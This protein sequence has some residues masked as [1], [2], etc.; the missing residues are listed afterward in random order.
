ML[1][2][3]KR[4][5][6]VLLLLVLLGTATI[7]GL[8][9]LS[10]PALDGKG[11][12]TTIDSTVTIARDAIGQAVVSADSRADASYGLG[13]AHG[14]D[15]FF[16]MDLLRRN[17]AGEL[18]EL[19]GSAAIN[20]DESMRFHQFRKRAKLIVMSLPESYQLML[21]RYTQGVND[22]R[23]QS[24]FTSFEYLLLGAT[25]KPW[26]PEDSLLVIFSMYLD[27]QTANFERD[28]ALIA[29]KQQYGQGMLDFILQ[30]SH[31]QAA[32]DG[33]VITAP[34]AAIPVIE[35]QLA[36][37]QP[38]HIEDI[39]LYGSNNW[40]V[41]GALTKTGAAMLSDDMHLGLTVPSIWYR[42][43]L[44][45]Q[46][47]G[48]E[49]QVTGVSLP[50]APA[51]VVGSNHHI[52]WGFTNGYLDAADWVELN[53]DTKTQQI[54]EEIML[55]SG[56][57]HT[58]QLEMSAFG[59]VKQV[60]DKKF[61]LSWVAHQPYAVNLELLQFELF[62]EV[63]EATA[64]AKNV[65]IPVQNLVVVD[66]QGS[67]AWTPIGAIPAR[68][69]ARDTALK[70]EEYESAWQNNERIRPV[71]QNP[72]SGKLWTANARVVS[73][74]DNQ[75]FGDGG[76]APGARAVQIRDGLISKQVFSEADF[77]QLQLD[78]QAK[79][80]TPWHERLVKLLQTQD[81]TSFEKDLRLLKDWQGCAC[82]DS[83]G[84]TLVKAYRNAL[85]DTLYAPL[86]QYLQTQSLSL[87]SVKGY[88][89]PGL[90]QLLTEQ[91]NSWLGAHSSWN[92]LELAA[93]Q[94][95]KQKLS[96]RYGSNMAAW[97]W[98][99][100]NALKV[101]HPFSKQMPMLSGLL[102][103]PTT[104]AFGD[105]FMPAVQGKAFGAS[106]RFIAQPGHLENAILTVAGG[107]SG[108]PL[109]PFYRTGFNDYAEGGDTPLLPSKITH[110]I[111][112]TP[113]SSK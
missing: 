108:H 95:A 15:R 98:G 32:L 22:G 102:D 54:A 79:F 23:A 80:L 34:T 31:H 47:R 21:E 99:D 64:H 97:R 67:A 37:H 50:G 88:F 55:P 92:E 29:L 106:Q 3:I 84:Y 73:T 16:Q 111:V 41:T 81:S 76:Y 24:G 30:P 110:Q 100:V 77:Y 38:S 48:K 93:Y 83:V 12:A 9:A 109:S 51:I 6:V 87:K 71:V 103:M 44:N 86:E 82:A 70:Q 65:G 53:S 78:N 25:P 94:L 18:S 62:S 2:W 69:F 46:E 72:E 85:I 68:K 19:F 13:F 56:E 74:E 35:P 105:T 113:N 60:G 33:S 104:Q 17:A 27:L 43:Q 4:I 26:L 8:L 101:Q 5:V 42:A 36:Q 58:Y 57:V 75:R 112:I 28:E 63:G 14:Q 1:T 39:P 90:W 66:S 40:A 107:Q 61:A 7:Y 59:P 96:E 20:L 89:E 10:L 49:V 45:Y 52:A 11:S 91:P